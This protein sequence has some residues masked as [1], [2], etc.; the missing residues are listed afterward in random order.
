MQVVL[1]TFPGIDLLGYAFKLE[2]FCV[3]QGGDVI[4]GGDIREE[5]YPAGRFD[6]VIGGP[7]CKWWSSSANIAKARGQNVQP[8]MIPEFVRVVTE[9]QPTW[10]LMENVPRA[11]VPRVDGYIAKPMVLDAADCGADQRRRRRFTFGTR[12]GR[13]LPVEILALRP[14]PRHNTVTCRNQQWDK[15]R[16]RP[17]SNN[18]A[19]TWPAAC[20]AQGVPVDFLGGAPFTWKGKWEVL[21]N[22]VP[23]PMG[24]AVAKAVQE[25]YPSTA[26]ALNSQLFPVNSSPL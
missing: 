26:L 14:A 24:R 19:K 5:H 18:S 3:V 7:P 8:D 22:A 23:L 21:G 16:Q 10:W 2:G 13:W 17:R 9:A 11:P 25:I 15:L 12:D 1:S 4:F 6:G 20:E